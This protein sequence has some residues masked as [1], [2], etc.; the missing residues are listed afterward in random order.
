MNKVAMIAAP[1]SYLA[2]AR[3][4]E[5]TTRSITKHSAT[6]QLAFIEA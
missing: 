3:Q 4:P 2:K 6:F 1:Y 5:S